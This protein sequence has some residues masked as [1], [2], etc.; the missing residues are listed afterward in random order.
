M[1]RLEVDLDFLVEAVAQQKAVDRRSV[2]VVLVFGRLARLRLDQDRA[3]ETYS[4]FVV[5]H[6]VKEAAELVELLPDAGVEQRFVAFAAAPQHIVFAAELFCR[7]E[8]LLDLERSKSKHLGVRV[9][10]RTAH[11]TPVAEQVGGAPQKLHAGRRLFGLKHIDHAAKVVDAVLG[12]RAFGRHV[13]VVKTVVRRAELCEKTERC[14]GLH[15]SGF[16]RVGELVPGALERAVVAEHIETVPGEAVP[17]ADRKPQLL[18]HA[19]AEHDAVALVPLESER[20]ARLRAFVGD[21]RDSFEIVGHGG[22]PRV[23]G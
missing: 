14:I 6:H 9:G 11:E 5:D 15:A 2:V 12:R 7:V 20:V 21:R 19:L 23:D 18:F 17:V 10:R 16:H 3:L 8:C 22:F 4:V 13:S 1:V